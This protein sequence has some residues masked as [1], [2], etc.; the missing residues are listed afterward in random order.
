[1][2]EKLVSLDCNSRKIHFIVGI[3]LLGLL[4]AQNFLLLLCGEPVFTKVMEVFT[5]IPG[6][7]VLSLFTV[8][9]A[10]T[11]YFTFGALITMDFLFSKLFTEQNRK[12]Y[13]RL[14]TGM[15]SHLFMFY[16]FIAVALQISP[17]HNNQSLYDKFSGRLA[18]PFS[19]VIY[20]LALLSTIYY[21]FTAFRNQVFKTN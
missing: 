20:G 7:A 2:K 19:A 6:F 9:V 3:I 18:D 13:P 5:R 16:S 14:I 8:A 10:L 17:G 12:C 21:L 11:Y 1:M 4:L 15:I